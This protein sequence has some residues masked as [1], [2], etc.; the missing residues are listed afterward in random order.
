MDIGPGYEASDS[1]NK[2]PH[3]GTTRW[4]RKFSLNSA[5]ATSLGLAYSS[6]AERLLKAMGS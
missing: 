5:T 2:R 3:L 4:T 1:V 6:G